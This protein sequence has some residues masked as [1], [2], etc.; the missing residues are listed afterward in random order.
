VAKN[1]LGY[2]EVS[3]VNFKTAILSYGII[4]RIPLRSIVTPEFVV[5][6]L[7]KTLRITEDRLTVI[8]KE[9]DL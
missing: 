5:V 1:G 6:A 4:A 3:T 8:T 7:S 2:S 9:A